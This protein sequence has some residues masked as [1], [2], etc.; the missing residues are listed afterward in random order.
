MSMLRKKDRAFTLVELLVVIGVLALLIAILLPVLS[1]VRRDAKRIACR[2]QLHDIGKLFNMYL[3][4]SRGKL[5]LVNSIPS[6]VPQLKGLAVP[7]L[8]APY[9]RDATRGWRCGEDQIRRRIKGTPDGF[10]T[11]FHREGISYFYNSQLNLYAFAPINDHP[12]YR[13]GKQNQLRVFNDFEPFHGRAGAGGS[14][15]YL[16]ADWHVGDLAYE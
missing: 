16:F 8:L 10:D 2:A 12:L 15:N 6:F 5:P 11:Y 13:A 9:A 14:C 4:D 1:G 3:N 7:E